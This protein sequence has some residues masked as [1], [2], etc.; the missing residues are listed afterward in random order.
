MH[1]LNNSNEEDNNNLFNANQ[2]PLQ[3]PKTIAE[4][5]K[6][7]SRDK[8]FETYKTN[9]TTTCQNNWSD[10]YSMIRKHSVYFTTKTT[11]NKLILYT[12]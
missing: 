8:H 6:K 7:N 1:S 2:T 10:G 9:L 11:S 5:L 3:R 4:I 12:S